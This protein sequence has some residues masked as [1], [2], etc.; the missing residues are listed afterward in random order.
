[1]IK[2]QPIYVVDG[3][4][5]GNTI[6]GTL[7]DMETD[8]TELETATVT[9]N[10]SNICNTISNPWTI[11]IILSALVVVLA[12][13]SVFLLLKRKKTSQEQSSLPNMPMPQAAPGERVTEMSE[14]EQEDPMVMEAQRMT[15]SIC[16]GIGKVHNI[17]RR[18]VQQD[19]LGMTSYKGGVLAVVADGM[20]GLSDGDKVSQKI[21]LT[22]MQDSVSLTGGSTEGKL[23]QMVAHVNSEVNHMLGVSDQYKSGSTLV[24]VLVEAGSFQWV[25]VGDSRIYLYTG[26]Q[27]LQINREHVYEAD[28]L[29]KAVNYEIAFEEIAQNPQKKSVSSFIGM[30][31]LKYID[32]SM[33]PVKIQPGDRIL[34]MSD[35]VFNT[36]TEQEICDVLMK[37]KNA[38]TAARV[39]ESQVLA[40]QNP[41]QDNF[42]AIILDI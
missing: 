19:S 42:T 39:L 21:V 15:D 3:T 35:G 2:K 29:K 22:M 34:L 40:H 28:L 16:R 36:L 23:Y 8:V 31:E 11:I 32:G 6:A 26:C 5:S 1:M 4:V 12:G 41:K 9:V 33:R 17:G 7:S 27:L 24:A 10:D 13:F 18:S 38:E 14:Q 30:G 25:S 20:G 37:E